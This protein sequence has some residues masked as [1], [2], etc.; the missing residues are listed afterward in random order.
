MTAGKSR[1]K[2]QSYLLRGLLLLPILLPIAVVGIIL[3][4]DHYASRQPPG[5][6]SIKFLPDTGPET[7][8]KTAFRH[9]LHEDELVTARMS[10]LSYTPG[11][12]AHIYRAHGNGCGCCIE[13]P[14]TRHRTGV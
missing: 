10:A 4:V 13:R 9:I 11:I 14:T 5:A 12:I 1:L 2:L 6:P 8:W 3:V 7:R